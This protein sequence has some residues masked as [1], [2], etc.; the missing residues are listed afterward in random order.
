M[1]NLYRMYTLKAKDI[2]TKNVTCVSPEMKIKE[3]AKIFVKDRINGAP[4]VDQNEDLVGIVS[5]SDIINFDFEKGVHASGISDY[6]SSTGLEPQQ[7]TDDFIATDNTIVSDATVKDLMMTNVLTGDP[8][9]SIPELSNKMYE[10]R[11]HRLVIIEG[12]KVFG[13]IST[14]DILKVVGEMENA[15]KEI[16]EMLDGALKA[17]ENL[18]GKIE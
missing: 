13:I 11:I 12:R 4:V 8:N 5:K 7:M 6:Y 2:M 15:R 14:L 9:D 17:I 1:I 10:K 3:L 18:K 16:N